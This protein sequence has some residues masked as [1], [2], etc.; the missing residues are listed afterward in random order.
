MRRTLVRRFAIPAAAVLLA[1]CASLV[2]SSVAGSLVQGAIN[3][4]AETAGITG[5][6]VDR[7]GELLAVEDDHTRTIYCMNAGSAAAAGLTPGTRVSATGKFESG[8]FATRS[9]APIGGTPWPAAAAATEVHGVT[10]GLILMQENHSFDN[11]FSS[12]PGTDSLPPDFSEEGAARFHLPS[13]TTPNLPHA[14]RT[15]QAATN[16]G[17]MDHFVS[18]EGSADTLGYY[19]SRDIPNY[20][21][22][23]KRFT[24]ADRFFSSFAGPTLPNHLFA[25][26]AQS[27]GV[28]RN[29]YRP[30][31]GGFGFA[32]L[33][34]E[35]DEAGVSWKCYIGKKDPRHFDALNPLAGFPS[36]LRAAGETRLA[37]TGELFKDIASGT[38]P[39]VAW[40]FPSPEESEHPP[41]D[42]RIG[43]WYVTAVVNALM[44]SSSWQ[45]TVLVVTWDEYGGFFDHVP[46]PTRNGT[47]LGPR[48]PALIVSPYARPGF[49][50]HTP[51][52]FS[53]ILRYV[54]DLFGV[55]A[56][57][58]WDRDAAS[59]A[60][61]LDS[62]PHPELP[63]DLAP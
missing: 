22:L 47:M 16:G 41:F 26:A 12:F 5:T 2:N 15:V 63:L 40:T 6:I 62:T 32:S 37:A 28:D 8:I 59:I 31:G 21:A 38:L 48:V 24:L 3:L 33:P 55:P 45:N 44:K 27:P 10:H 36:L 61:A 7:T 17:K 43:M 56:L 30:P 29:L 51:Y 35:L 54:E 19:D 23:A 39:S 34:D 1:S 14:A 20:W 52:D 60:G 57:T 9:L 13:P 42:V 50:D 11:Y 46:P 53:S 18:A 49:V 25:V 58:A 4:Q